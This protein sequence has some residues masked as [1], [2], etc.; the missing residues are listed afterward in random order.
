MQITVKHNQETNSYDVLKAC[1]GK[2]H[3][4]QSNKSLVEA[5]KAEEALIKKGK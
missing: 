4:V 5:Q 2:W 1:K 3:V